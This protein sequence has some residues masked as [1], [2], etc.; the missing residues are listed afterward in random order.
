MLFYDNIIKCSYTSDE[1]VYDVL[2]DDIQNGFGHDSNVGPHHLLH[3]VDFI[4]IWNH[5]E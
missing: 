3:G 2:R 1:Q 4:A 5:L